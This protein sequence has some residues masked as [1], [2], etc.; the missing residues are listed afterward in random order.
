MKMTPS[1]TLYC[2]MVSRQ[3][4]SAGCMLVRTREAGNVVCSTGTRLAKS[5][6]DNRRAN[7]YIR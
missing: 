2:R 5:V 1:L 4:A 7:E 3:S 6:I